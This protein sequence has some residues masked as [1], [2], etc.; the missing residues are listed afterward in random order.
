MSANVQFKSLPPLRRKVLKYSLALVGLF[1]ALGVAMMI[2]VFLA[3][4]ITPRLIHRNYDSIEAARKMQQAWVAEHHPAEYPGPAPSRWTTQFEEALKFEQGNITESGEREIA[5]RISEDWEKAKAA[6]FSPDPALYTAMEKELDALIAVNEKGMFAL[7]ESSTDLSHRVLLGSMVL[8]LATLLVAV[9][10]ADALAGR[11]ATPLKQFAEALRRKPMPGSKLKLPDPTSLEMRI[12]THEMSQL[13]DRLS[14]LQKL[15]LDELSTQRRKLEA[16]LAS[17]DDAILVVDNQSLIIQC[18]EG[19]LRMLGLNLAEVVGKAWADLSTLSDNYLR[20]RALLASE[21]T[22]DQ[23]TVELDAGGRKRTYSGRRRPFFGDTG[24]Q[25]G[26]LYLLH[27]ITETRQRDRLKTEFIGVLSHELKTPLQSLGTASELLYARRASAS[28]EEEKMLI[29]TV[30]EDVGRI[31]A[32][33]NEFIQVGLVD[34]HSLRLK[35]GRVPVNELLPQ[36]I[37]PF[38]VLAKDKGVKVDFVKEG[39]DQIDAKV[40][41]V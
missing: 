17:V 33:A 4:G 37:Q 12:L 9:Y 22:S 16:V 23:N 31:R 20:L 36:W 40:D 2:A 24:N 8:F 32:V 6:H 27:D 1:A 21:M 13:W 26:T 3:S 34:L 41:A 38:Q 35:I 29:E 28:D 15:N 18:N 39:S 5:R 7:A 11:I 30:H 14:D 19:M 25:I 10:L